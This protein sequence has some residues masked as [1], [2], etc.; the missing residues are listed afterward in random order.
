MPFREFL[1]IL[2]AFTIEN[3]ITPAA[4][5]A[6]NDDH[7]R[8]TDGYDRYGNRSELQNDKNIRGVLIQSTP[9][10]Q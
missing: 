3:R 2:M 10:K 1:G 6:D 7:I 4:A 9:K 5:G 8:V